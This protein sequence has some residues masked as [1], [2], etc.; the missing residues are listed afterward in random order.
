MS[1][2]LTEQKATVILRDSKTGLHD[3]DGDITTVMIEL[4][5]AIETRHPDAW[6]RDLFKLVKTYVEQHKTVFIYACGL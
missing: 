5:V 1:K 4:P 3:I 6:K 2:L